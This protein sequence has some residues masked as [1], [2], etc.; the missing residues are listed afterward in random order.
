VFPFI[1]S[2]RRIEGRE[3]KDP[4]FGDHPDEQHFVP[5]GESEQ[6]EHGAEDD[7]GGAETVSVVDETASPFGVEKTL[8]SVF[9]F[10]VCMHD[11][12]DLLGWFIVLNWKN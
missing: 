5:E 1:V 12:T 11:V 3:D 10:I 6:F 4:A 2:E 9:E 8:E 7:D